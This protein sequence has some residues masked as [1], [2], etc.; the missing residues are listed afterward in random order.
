MS[1]CRLKFRNICSFELS[2]RLFPGLPKFMGE[3]GTSPPGRE[4]AARNWLTSRSGAG[5]KGGVPL[6][7]FPSPQNTIIIY[8]YFEYY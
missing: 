3:A 2:M 7:Q 8:K 4:A 6:A 5:G 1:S